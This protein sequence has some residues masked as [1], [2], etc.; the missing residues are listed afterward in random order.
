M[1]YSAGWDKPV[2]SFTTVK[3]QTNV[4]MLVES[5]PVPE[6]IE[7]NVKRMLILH[8][9]GLSY[10]TFRRAYLE[11]TGNNLDVNELGF[12]KLEMFLV[13]LAVNHVLEMSYEGTNI[14]V[15]PSKALLDET[16]SHSVRGDW[17]TMS[18]DSLL[19]NCTSDS[20]N[21]SEEVMGPSD[22]LQ[23]QE[24][25]ADLRVGEK[26]KDLLEVIVAEVFTPYRFY[27]QLKGEKTSKQLEILMD[28]MELFYYREPGEKYRIPDARIVVG[29]VCASLYTDGNWHR[30]KI[31][32]L[33]DLSTVEV[34]YVDYGTNTRVKKDTLRYLHKKFGQLP[35]Q[36]IKARLAGIKPVD[37]LRRWDREVSYRLLEL[38]KPCQTGLVA[39][40]RGR[41][42]RL[43]LWLTDTFTNDLPAGIVIN[44]VLVDEGLAE[45]DVILGD[46]SPVKTTKPAF[47]H[48]LP[49]RRPIMSPPRKGVAHS[50]SLPGGGVV[51]SESQA[52]GGV[53][54]SVLDT[55]PSA[56]CLQALVGQRETLAKMT[57]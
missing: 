18:S 40:V 45:P 36:A 50:Q 49:L 6:H 17:K 8:S 30:A 31:T 39:R 4:K 20:K 47:D 27:V 41:G 46:V 53:A 9:Q 10:Q 44:Q 11:A 37:G 56:P 55:P 38:V 19:V 7:K 33:K 48:L 22:K 42:D 16:M 12:S 21:R 52:R 51:P 2:E 26:D 14:V 35:A 34:L 13:S 5:P 3:E 43:W 15:K 23:E 32:A 28:D 29:L 24:L 25:P 57:V 54:S 1:L